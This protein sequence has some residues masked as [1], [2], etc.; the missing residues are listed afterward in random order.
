MHRALVSAAAL[1]AV[2]SA[3]GAPAQTA[4]ESPLLREGIRRAVEVK[5]MDLDVVATKGGQPVNDLRKEDF[6]VK[7][8]GKVVPLDYFTRVDAGTLHGPDLA[9]ASPDLV[10]ETLQNDRGDRYLARQFLVFFDDEHLLPFERNKVIENLRDFVQR[11]SPSDR[12]SIVSYGA[13]SRI[14]LPFTSSKE[15]LL[16]TL[17]KLEKIAPGGVHWDNDYR[18][19][20]LDLQRTRGSSRQS[21]IRSWSQQAYVREKSTLEDL[22]RAVTALAARSGKRILML[23]SDGLE[24]HPGQIL[25]QTFGPFSLSQWDYSVTNDL[26]SVI[27]EANAAGV[28]VH[29]LD[30]KGLTNDSDASQSS[31]SPF[32]S[33]FVSQTLKEPLAEVTRQTGGIL[34]TNRN[35]FQTGIDR[36]YQEASSYYSIGITVA[37]LEGKTKEHKVDVG[38]TR[39]G[40]EIRTRRTFTAKSAQDA[41]RDRMEMALLN[42]GARGD[43]PVAVAIGAT[44]KGGGL[45]HRLAPYEVRVP[46]SALTFKDEGE[47]KTATFEVALAA[48]RDNGERSGF[49]PDRKTVSIPASEWEKAKGDAFRYTGEMKTGTG[50]FRFVATVRDVGT[51]AVGIGTAS[52]HID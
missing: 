28:T 18:R 30:A 39:P 4:T 10:L 42:P 15:D 21:V 36:I 22:R 13:T 25:Q 32:S 3:A 35:S 24:L 29:A 5:A 31:P 34:L 14:V 1:A 51:D 50:N 37:S 12:M 44:K 49:R 20:T 48:I 27:A 11:L 23:V 41:T 19:T 40:V 43:F 26:S 8:D 52:V 17:S 47:K 9:N 2:L 46:M 33:F 45:G 7:V 16:D 6:V 38:V